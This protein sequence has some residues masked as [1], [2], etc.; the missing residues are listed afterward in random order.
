MARLRLRTERNFRDQHAALHDAVVE[1]LVFQR[2]TPVDA[3]RHDGHRTRGER[4]F[5]GCRVDSPG[6]ARGNDETLLAEILRD[7]PCEPDAIGR[8]VAGA[9]DGEYSRDQ[10]MAVSLDGE[11]GRRVGDGRQAFRIVGFAPRDETRSRG[12][13][14]RVFALR[15]GAR[16]HADRLPPSAPAGELGQGLERGGGA[17]EMMQELEEGDR[18]DI[19]G[20]N[21][22]KPIETLRLREGASLRAHASRPG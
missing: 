2:V 12:R 8:R 10:Q 20:A 5:M 19:L 3:A 14:R 7:F 11:N 21:E 15:R 22:A 16:Q 4:P 9:D 1:G 18:P 17:A 6:Q 13:R